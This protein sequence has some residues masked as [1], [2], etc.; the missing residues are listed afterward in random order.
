MLTPAQTKASSLVFTATMLTLFPT[1]K[2]VYAR[3]VSPPMVKINYS[4]TTQSK[5]LLSRLRNALR[6]CCQLPR[7]SFV[8]T[9]PTGLPPPLRL[10]GTGSISFSLATSTHLQ[11]HSD[12]P[13]VFRC[14]MT[15]Y[16]LFLLIR[17]LPSLS[18]IRG[19]GKT[20]FNR[21]SRPSHRF[22]LWQ[23][24]ASESPEL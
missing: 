18:L 21:S 5:P 3:F 10:A 7:I 11:H 23:R 9:R 13:C 1:L 15:S 22:N 6:P 14:S 17:D 16:L 19:L 4:S 12:W 2:P 20:H 8:P 24:N